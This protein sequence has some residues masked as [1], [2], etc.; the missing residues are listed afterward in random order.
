MTLP[1][2]D[3]APRLG[4]VGV[5]MLHTAVKIVYP[6]SRSGIVG[7]EEKDELVVAEYLVIGGY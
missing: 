2:D 4:T 6:T 7:V 1:L 5:A 3:A